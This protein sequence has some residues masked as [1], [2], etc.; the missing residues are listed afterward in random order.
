MVY[1]SST[2]LTVLVLKAAL[3]ENRKTFEEH[4]LFNHRGVLMKFD[5]NDS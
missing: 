3:A 2:K 4:L 5:R 1:K